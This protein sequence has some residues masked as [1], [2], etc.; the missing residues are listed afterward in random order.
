M[1]PLSSCTLPTDA[2]PARTFSARCFLS[3]A[4]LPGPLL[5]NCVCALMLT[6]AAQRKSALQAS[7]RASELDAL[8]PSPST[9][10][11][12][13]TNTSDSV[14]ADRVPLRPL[15]LRVCCA[16]YLWTACGRLRGWTGVLVWSPWCPQWLRGQCSTKRLLA[17]SRQLL[18]CRGGFDLY[19]MDVSNVH[20]NNHE[21]YVHQ[22]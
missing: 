6:D 18:G 15:L 13:G 12:L 5:A 21:R 16:V 1:G 22:A 17:R 4:F 7:E 8:C 19:R 20:L 9:H 10:T 2:S 3:S 11:D 14:G